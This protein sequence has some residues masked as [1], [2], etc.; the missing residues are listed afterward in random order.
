M[1]GVSSAQEHLDLSVQQQQ[2][3]LYHQ[4]YSQAPIQPSLLSN[5]CNGLSD[6]QAVQDGLAGQLEREQQQRAQLDMIDDSSMVQ[7]YLDGFPSP[8]LFENLL[9]EYVKPPAPQSLELCGGKHHITLV[10]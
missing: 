10:Y 1:Q 8:A 4:G 2:H 6:T 3:Q 5:S 9:N 7:E